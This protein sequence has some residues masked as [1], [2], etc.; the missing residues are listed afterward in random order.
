[1]STTLTNQYLHNLNEVNDYVN[2]MP[3]ENNKSRTTDQFL[4]HNCKKRECV[5]YEMQPRIGDRP[6]TIFINCLNIENK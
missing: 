1:M 2:Q 5:F 6:M 3:S 4:Y